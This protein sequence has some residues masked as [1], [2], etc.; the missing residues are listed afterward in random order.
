MSLNDNPLIADNDDIAQLFTQIHHLPLINIPS[1]DGIQ[2]N[3]QLIYSS[4]HTSLVF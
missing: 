4:L 1:P 3:Y 2:I